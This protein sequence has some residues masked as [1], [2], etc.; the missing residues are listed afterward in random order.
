MTF[1]K[2]HP[3]EAG[4]EQGNRHRQGWQGVTGSKRKMPNK[5]SGHC[6]GL[7]PHVAAGIAATCSNNA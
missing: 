4:N 7:A 1:V 2:T 6:R 3:V 5:D